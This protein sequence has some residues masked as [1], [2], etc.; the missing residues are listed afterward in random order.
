[1]TLVNETRER[2]RGDL[3]D[4]EEKMGLIMSAFSF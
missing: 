1:M 4:G 3:M 2:E